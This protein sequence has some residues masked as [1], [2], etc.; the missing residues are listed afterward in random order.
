MTASLSDPLREDE[1]KALREAIRQEV[2]L[3]IVTEWL[4]MPNRLTWDAHLAERARQAEQNRLEEMK[5]GYFPWDDVEKCR[6]TAVSIGAP[7]A[8]LTLRPHQRKESYA[9]GAHPCPFCGRQADQLTWIYFVS[10]EWT[11]QKLCGRAGWLTV[12]DTCHAQIN[13]FCEQM[14]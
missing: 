8:I 4:S 11:W 3:G 12:C 2:S 7:P 13:F 5:R 6:N 14:S 1:A 9:K 10:P